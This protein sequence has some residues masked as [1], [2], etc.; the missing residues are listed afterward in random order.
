MI[1]VNLGL[2]GNYEKELQ[3]RLVARAEG[4]EAAIHDIL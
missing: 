1:L 2:K 4:G 3:S